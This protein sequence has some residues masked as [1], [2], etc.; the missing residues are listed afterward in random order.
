LCILDIMG[1]SLRK[2]LEIASS[3]AV[4]QVVI[5]GPTELASG[6][7]TVRNMK[8]GS[9]ERVLIVELPVTLR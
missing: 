8:E 6:E 5:V 4:E 9:E 1:R 2:Q 7:V 3:R